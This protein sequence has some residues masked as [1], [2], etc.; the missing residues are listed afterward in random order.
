MEDTYTFVIQDV[1]FMQSRKLNIYIYLQK[2]LE[3]H[4][5]LCH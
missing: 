3:L 4:L 5:A 1:K 2:V